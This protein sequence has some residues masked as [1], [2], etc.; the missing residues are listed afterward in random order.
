MKKF[1]I[2]YGRSAALILIAVSLALEFMPFAVELHF[3][4][5]PDE[6]ELG[7][8]KA[9]YPY[10]SPIPFGYAVF[11]PLLIFALT[12]AALV[13]VAV[14]AI[15]RG[16]AALTAA[17]VLCAACVALSAI[18]AMYA[19]YSFTAAAA[20]ITTLHAVAAAALLAVR[21]V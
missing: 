12:C 5:P 15:S 8:I 19:F 14:S 10:Y 11:C 6:S 3:G 20:A 13:T 9:T 17:A 7:Y 2:K 4:V 16:R 18:W 1:L 21:C